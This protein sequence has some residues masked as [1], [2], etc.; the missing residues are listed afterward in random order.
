ML[1]VISFISQIESLND[2]E[3]KYLEKLF[4]QKDI[5]KNM[6]L[7]EQG[8][9]SQEV[10]FLDNGLMAMIYHRNNKKFI[11]DF[12]FEN[13]PAI[14]Y[15]S[16]FNGEPSSYSIMAITDCS[17]QVITKENYELAKEKISKMKSIV[18]KLTNIGHQIIEDRF[19][20]LIT[21]TAEERYLELLNKKPHL[22][23]NIPLKLIA[24]YLGITNVALSR[25]RKRISLPK[26][27]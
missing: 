12:I 9:V 17:I 5:K 1:D 8:L 23:F 14:V 2:K 20:S 21:L 3:K 18:Y 13:N 26:N 24:S 19:R 7:I 27:N 11:K 25:I 10:Y 15:P 4:I 16:F 6:Y 22:L